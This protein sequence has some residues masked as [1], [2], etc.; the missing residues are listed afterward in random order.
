MLL[1]EP[2]PRVRT[3]TG[4]AAPAIASAR[5][6]P[7][8]AAASAATVSAIGLAI[9]AASYYLE[10]SGDGFAH[11]VFWGGLATLIL[12]LA[13]VQLAELRRGQRIAL[14]VLGGL[15]LYAVKVLHD[16]ALF[17]N[18]DEFTHLAATQQ[19]QASH[20]LYEELPIGGVM[21]ANG[22]PGLHIAT[23]A[24]SDLS[25]LPLHPSGLLVIGAARVIF[26]LAVY[27]IAERLTKSPMTAALAA[28]LVAANGNFI[29]WSGQFSYESLSLPLFLVA[30][31]LAA[32]RN[33]VARQRGAATLA[34]ALVTVAVIATHHLTSYALA[35]CLWGLTAL[36]LRARWRHLRC[37]DLAVLA[38]AGAG[39][40]FAL[41][42]RSTGSYLSYVFNRT[43]TAIT[44]VAGN[45]THTPFQDQAGYQTPV[46]E[47]G[48]GF[49]AAGVISLAIVWGMWV[50]WR[51]RDRFALA[52]AILLT[53]CSLAY[54][55]LFPLKL[56]PGAWETVNRS[57]NFTSVGAA[58]VVAA[59]V[60]AAVSRRRPGRLWRTLA[61]TA[62]TLAVCGATIQGWPS[63]VLLSQPLGVQAGDAVLQP[64]GFAASAWAT[65]RLP[66]PS[67]Y[68]ADEVTGRELAVDGAAF[69]LSGRADGVREVLSRPAME[70]WQLDLL[71]KSEVDFAVVDRRRISA[72]NVTG[73]FFQR[74][75]APDGGVG[76]YSPRARAKFAALP[77]SSRVFDS[78]NIVI[79]DIRGLRDGPADCRDLY[80]IDLPNERACRAGGKTTLFADAHSRVDYGRGRTLSLVDAYVERRSKSTVVD[81]SLQAL[82]SAPA[83]AVFDVDR[84]ALHVGTRKIHVVA[85]ARR[86]FA[87]SRGR[88]TARSHRF[89]RLRVVLRGRAARR[90]ARSG[91]YLTVPSPTDRRVQARY[92]FSSKGTPR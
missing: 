4:P 76:Y 28:I 41:V 12:P 22:F 42:A 8:G 32:N 66:A 67:V 61:A 16:P 65:S 43:Y 88:A 24:L 11:P 5:A 58:I 83:P 70:P 54:L 1:Q 71:R 15:L 23:V 29:F 9:V 81:L 26:V 46:A 47:R 48:L 38:T 35:A 30:L 52:T 31:Y 92:D 85:P 60:A 7:R 25:G 14:V 21:V 79:Y 64:E 87:T 33:D 3:D 82:N 86:G 68:L 75:D 27:L 10:R 63:R 91:A 13:L 51:R 39:L 44:D 37:V 59:A 53:L 77:R 56:F 49:A 2:Q 45:G 50:L 36:S 62:I 40:W 84:I 18:S 69:T 73:Y 19:L 34:A 72:N 57:A 55:S 90:F 89:G 6:G 80:A 78:G 17:A 20:H 74:A